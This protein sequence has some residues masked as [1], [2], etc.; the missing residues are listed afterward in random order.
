[1]AKEK[2]LLLVVNEDEGLIAWADPVADITTEVVRR[3]E[4]RAAR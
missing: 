1:V 3:L 4:P 2:G